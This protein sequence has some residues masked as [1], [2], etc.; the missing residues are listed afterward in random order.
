MNP[1][2]ILKLAPYFRLSYQIY[3]RLRKAERRK[4]LVETLTSA[5]GDEKVSKTEWEQIGS[6]LGVFEGE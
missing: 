5:V 3:K 2:R 1:L 6:S 4:E